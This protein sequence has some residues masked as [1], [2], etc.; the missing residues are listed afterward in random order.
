MEGCGH[1]PRNA[2]NHLKLEEVSRGN[3]TSQHLD[4]HFPAFSTRRSL[5]LPAFG[6]WISSPQSGLAY[7]SDTFLTLLS[8]LDLNAESDQQ[9]CL[10]LHLLCSIIVIIKLCRFSCDLQEILAPGRCKK[11][12]IILLLLLHRQVDQI[13]FSSNQPPKVAVQ[14]HDFLESIPCVHNSGPISKDC[15]TQ[16]SMPW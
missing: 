8:R 3:I 15:V 7:S 5:A 16:Q 6:T 2:C 11:L 14:D 1:K 13:H 12:A 4:F 10:H 9:S